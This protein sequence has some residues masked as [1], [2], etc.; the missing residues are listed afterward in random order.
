MSSLR[1]VPPSEWRPFF[2]RMSRGLL[3]RLAE[4][5]VASLDLG[6]QVVAEWIPLFGITYDAQDNSL[7]VVLDRATHVIR[8]P[9]EIAVEETADGLSS[10]A[11]VD[12]AGER[13]VIRLK[14]PLKL[15]AA[16]TSSS[17]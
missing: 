7:D 8:Q 12:E 13:Q 9:R 14:Q 2:D 3:G 6:D 10:V 4:I 5:E 17:R 1:T 15:P 16:A 11:V